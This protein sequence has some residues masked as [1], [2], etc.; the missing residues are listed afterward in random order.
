[1]REEPG[2][3][4]LTD[5]LARTFERTVVRSLG[6]DRHPELRDAYFKQLPPGGVPGPAA[7][8]E[9]ARAGARGGRPHRPAARGR[10]GRRGRPRARSGAPGGDGHGW[11][12]PSPPARRSCRRSARGCG[13]SSSTWPR[14]GPGE[15]RVRLHASG[16]CSDDLNAFDG[17]I[18]VPCPAVLGH[19]GAGVVE[20][21]GEGV[22]TLAVGDHVALSWAPYCGHCE[23]CLRD[24]PHL[25]GTAWPKMLAGGLLDGTTR[26]SLRRRHRAP[27]LLPLV[28]RRARGRARALVRAHPRR[29]AL[30]RRGARR[31]APSRAACAP[32]GGRPACGPG[33]RVAVFG[34]GGTGL[35]AVIGSVAAGASQIVA[36]DARE[37]RLERARELGATST[38]SGRGRPPRSRPPCATQAAAASTTPSRP[39]AGRRRPR[40]RSSRPAP[41]AR[42]CCAASPAPTPPSPCRRSRSRAWSG[43]CWARSTARPGPTATSR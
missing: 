24:L 32:S 7:D 9:P 43:A 30:R 15:V 26:L 2:T 37:S 25:C 28:V 40:P 34:L 3:Y 18:E 19:E 22:T 11:L 12:T 35:A 21:I 20:E 14:P 38:S 33:E 8:A 23:Q 6:L 4:F 29:R 1:M 42:R 17:S 13:S 16:V 10:R 5:F 27:L 41:A 39:A 31:A 36:V